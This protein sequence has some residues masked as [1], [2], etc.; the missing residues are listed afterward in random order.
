MLPFLLCVPRR[1]R[2][3]Q[4]QQ[5]K[6]QRYSKYPSHHSTCLIAQYRASEPSKTG[7]ACRLPKDLTCGLASSD[8][9]ALS[10][11]AKGRAEPRCSL[12]RDAIAALVLYAFRVKSGVCQLA[13]QTSTKRLASPH[14][15]LRSLFWTPKSPWS[16][17]WMSVWGVASDCN[18]V[19]SGGGINSIVLCVHF[20]KKHVYIFA[21]QDSLDKAHEFV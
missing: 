10:S 16:L 14:W 12:S 1:S 11:G 3:G 21:A 13:V 18:P 5:A 17:R 15:N 6:Q 7:M 8:T 20:K 4:Q 19:S 9:T 2:R